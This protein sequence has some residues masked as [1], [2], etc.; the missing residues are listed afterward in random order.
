MKNFRVIFDTVPLGGWRVSRRVADAALQSW[1]QRTTESD[2]AWYLCCRRHV[3]GIASELGE[4][5]GIHQV[6]CIRCDT[7]HW[8]SHDPRWP[9][10]SPVPAQYVCLACEEEAR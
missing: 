5:V 3:A 4:L 1:P 10:S 8:L 6:R 2:E 9:P 7:Q